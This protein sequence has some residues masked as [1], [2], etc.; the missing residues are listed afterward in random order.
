MSWS[1]QRVELDVLIVGSGPVGATFARTL[2]EGGRKVMMVDAGPQLS[3]RPGEHLKNHLAYQHSHKRFGALIRGHLHPLTRRTRSAKPI[4]PLISLDAGVATYAVGGMATHWTGVTP[5]HHPTMERSDAIAADEW[6]TLY[7]EAE[8]LLRTDTDLTGD[9]IA[10]QIVLDAL[11][12][13]Y[14]ELPAPY[15]PR[16]LPMAAQR[17]ADTPGLVR[18]TGVDT[19]L[20]PLVD[21]HEGFTLREQHHCARL[22]PTADGSRIAYAEVVDHI[23]WRTLRVEA[24]TYVIACGAVLTP[25][26]LYAS[27]IRPPALGRYLTE[28][29]VAFCQVLLRDAL[30]DQVAADPRFADRVAAHRTAHPSDPVPIPRDDLDPNVWIP[31]SDDRPWHCQIHRDLP[32]DDMVPNPEIDDRLVVD[33][34]WFGL[35]DPRPENRVLFSDTDRDVYGMPEPRFE[36]SLSEQDRTRQHRM[37][38]DLR[39]AAAA[40]GP[41]L[42][43]SE[44]RFVLPTLPLH[45]AGT[46]RMGTDP[47]TSVVDTGSKVWGISNLYLGGNGL[48]PTA[49]A[50]NPTLTSVAMALRAARGICR[51]QTS[52]LSRKAHV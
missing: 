46:A 18:W 38:A 39:R 10:H 35:V 30:I 48:I 31:V 9:A 44:P 5:R 8:A 23:H 36:F 6:E 26:L 34:R 21:G 49:T 3:S 11:A 19:I 33:L 12:A 20:G 25:Q 43:G 7:R 24:E 17:R 2:V 45:I 52:T 32:Y 15:G 29:P 28:Q 13:E 14:R 37:M 50:S 1:C 4:D 40:L 41:F 16:H 47:D 27:G 22:V 42:P 51:H